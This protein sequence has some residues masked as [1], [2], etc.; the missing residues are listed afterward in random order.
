MREKKGFT[1]PEML[2]VLLL[3]GLLSG[4]AVPLMMDSWQQVRLDYAI[5]QLHRDLRWAQREAVKEQCRVTVTF[6]RDR[7]PYRYVIRYAGNPVNQRYRE[8]PAGLDQLTSQTL[9]IEPDKEFQKNGHIMLRKGEH[10]RYVYYYQ[11]GR[12]RITKAPTA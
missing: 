3:I 12:T 10:E 8:L 2:V 6:Y 11:T 5:Q 9:T 7:Q 1:L 4:L